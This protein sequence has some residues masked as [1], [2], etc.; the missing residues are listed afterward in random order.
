MPDITEI[1]NPELSRCPYS[2]TMR[3]G[4]NEYCICPKCTNRSPQ[5]HESLGSCKACL[6]G[7]PN[8]RN[9]DEKECVIEECVKY[10]YTSE[11]REYREMT[12]V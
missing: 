7:C 6:G 11:A 9:T 10:E 2:D 1:K 5:C 3:E 4:T 12:Y 8:R